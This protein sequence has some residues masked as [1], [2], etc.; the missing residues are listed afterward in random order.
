MYTACLPR[1]TAAIL[2]S[3]R[4]CSAA[5]VKIEGWRR[6]ESGEEEL[7]CSKK[8]LG[9]STDALSRIGAVFFQCWAA[10]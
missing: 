5:V 7:Q 3:R 2:V 9:G 8:G 1:S 4:V 10:R 6:V